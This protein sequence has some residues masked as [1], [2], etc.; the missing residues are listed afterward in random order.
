MLPPQLPQ[1]S[2]QVYRT[3]TQARREHHLHGQ[4]ALNKFQL[5]PTQGACTSTSQIWHEGP[6]AHQQTDPQPQ[7]PP[8]QTPAKCHRRSFFSPAGRIT[9]ASV[10]C[11]GYGQPTGHLE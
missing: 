9:D 11:S 10:A 7:P 2:K 1:N 8:R 4:S 6:G 3:G 5:R